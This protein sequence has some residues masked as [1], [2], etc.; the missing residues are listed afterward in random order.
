MPLS[1]LVEKIV[2]SHTDTTYRNK[3]ESIALL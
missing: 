2:I 3:Q 1:I